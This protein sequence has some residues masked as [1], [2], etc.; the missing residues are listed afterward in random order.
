M[1]W[2]KGGGYQE[3]MKG[4]R[5]WSEHYITFHVFHFI[6]M[7]RSY[8]RFP[9][10][11]PLCQCLLFLVC[12]T[13]VTAFS[14]FLVRFVF[15]ATFSDALTQICEGLVPGPKS[16]LGQVT[17]PHS[18]RPHKW[19]L[20]PSIRFKTG[21]ESETRLES[22][23]SDSLLGRNVRY[24]GVFEAWKSGYSCWCV[25]HNTPYTFVFLI[26]VHLC[27]WPAWRLWRLCNR[28]KCRAWLVWRLYNWYR[29]RVLMVARAHGLG[30]YSALIRYG[31]VKRHIAIQR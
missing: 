7:N 23:V 28:Y 16:I 30:L 18:A 22:Y 27:N 26:A 24:V 2:L 31:N 13:W 29:C 8:I 10:P 25:T 17:R 6:I 12:E 15:V 3:E 11:L 4:D 1:S 19:S 21:A 9:S 5:Y 14:W 20:N